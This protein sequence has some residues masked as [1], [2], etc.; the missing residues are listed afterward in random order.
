MFHFYIFLFGFNP[1]I[2]FLDR[3]TF[4]QG[5][6][7][8]KPQFS[9]NIELTHTFKGFLN[10]TLNYTR[11]TDII[12]DVLEQDPDKNETVIR[13]Q[14][15]AKQRQY[16]IAVS[17]GGQITKWRSGNI[18]ANVYN[19]QCLHYGAYAPHQGLLTIHLYH[20]FHISW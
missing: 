14:N 7:N 20:N 15:I 10:T 18:Y 8:L 19:S 16:G 5:N 9:H 13:N 6:P 12:N 2:I 3:Y 17:A 11:T 1:F 4:E